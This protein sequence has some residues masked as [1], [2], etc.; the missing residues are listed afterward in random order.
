M[1]GAS[2]VRC[3]LWILLKWKFLHYVVTSSLLGSY[4]PSAYFF[5]TVS[6][7]PPHSDEP[8]SDTVIPTAKRKYRCLLD[9]TPCSLVLITDF[10]NNLLSFFRVEYLSGSLLWNSRLRHPVIR[11]KTPALTITTSHKLIILCT[12]ILV[13]QEWD[14]DICIMSCPNR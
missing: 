8:V 14:G 1:S 6:S 2:A 4:Q 12:L 10:Q 11:Q 9:V 3:I 7:V 13:L 5:N